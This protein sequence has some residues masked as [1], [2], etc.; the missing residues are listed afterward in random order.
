MCFECSSDVCFECSS[1]VCALSDA[2][3]P[4]NSLENALHP[5]PPCI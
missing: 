4:H 5:G 1:G 2:L 3:L